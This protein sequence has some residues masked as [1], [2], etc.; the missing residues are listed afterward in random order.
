M[1][2]RKIQYYPGYDIADRV[3]NVSTYKVIYIILI[4]IQG[5]INNYVFNYLTVVRVKK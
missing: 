3:I 2:V 1:I 5:K 4:F